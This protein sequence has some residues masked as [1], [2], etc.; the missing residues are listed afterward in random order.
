MSRLRSLGLALPARAA[1]A[2]VALTRNGARGDFTRGYGAR[3]SL[4][5]GSDAS[6]ARSRAD[7]G[8]LLVRIIALCEALTLALILEVARAPQRWSRAPYERSIASCAAISP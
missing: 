4:S 3:V 2:N 1:D 7:A 8:P 5:A 6:G